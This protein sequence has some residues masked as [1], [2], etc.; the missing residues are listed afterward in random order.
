MKKL[1]SALLLLVIT[2][3]TA[4]AQLMFKDVTIYSERVSE[5]VLVV[6][7]GKI[8][9]DAVVAIA[10]QKGLVVIDAG[11]SPT[12]TK[13]YRRIIEKEFGRN[14]FVYLINTHHHF[15][16]TS[17]N[18]VFPEATIISHQKV[19]ALMKEWDNNRRAFVNTRRNTQ[20]PQWKEQRKKS[21]PGS[22]QWDYFNDIVTTQI[23]ML[24]DYE[25]NYT[26]TLPDIIFND[27]MTLDLGN[28][29][30]N[31]Y[32]FGEG[33][34]TGDD[35]IVH[36]P[37]EKLLFVGDLFHPDYF[38]FSYTPTFD[39]ERQIA[40]FEDIYQNP[41]SVNWAFNCHHKPLSGSFIR[42]WHRYLTEAWVAISNAKSKG[43][44][45][46][47]VL[48]EFTLEKQF[49]YILESGIKEDALKEMHSENLK[50]VWNSLNS[51]HP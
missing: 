14:D 5:Q 36:C 30:L 3:I 48:N 46:E 33:L 38:R 24:D 31:L 45:L 18:Q 51:I 13:E 21:V 35:I 23:I 20:L 12:L 43:K 22:E 29:T 37:E 6:W 25:Q 44:D 49:S 27:R 40:V 9:K 15:D 39:A 2:S 16:H 4:C 17:G 41:N 47:K 1:I 10:T 19:S 8:Y 50:A 34:H 42:L 11:K 7:G 32:Y 26:L 28:L